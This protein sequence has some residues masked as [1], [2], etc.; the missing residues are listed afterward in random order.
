MGLTLVMDQKKLLGIITDGDLRRAFGKEGEVAHLL[1][2]QMM[3]PDPLTVKG[4][5]RFAE[6]EAYMQQK[7]VRALVVVDAA[8][9]TI[10]VLQIYDMKNEAPSA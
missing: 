10:G 1:A 3:T 9:E 5:T 6:A 2:S 7:E 8:E 4:N